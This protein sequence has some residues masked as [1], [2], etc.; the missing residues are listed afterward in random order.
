M[1]DSND[2]NHLI[3]FK[4]LVVEEEERKRQQAKQTHNLLMSIVVFVHDLYIFCDS[5]KCR[6]MESRNQQ[7]HAYC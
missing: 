3:K 6:F 1:F 5:C 7:H 2:S 4:I